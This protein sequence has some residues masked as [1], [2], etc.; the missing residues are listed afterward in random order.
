MYCMVLLTLESDW[1]RGLMNNMS[2]LKLTNKDFEVVG[3]NID[4]SERIVRVSLTYWNDAWRRLK[5]NRLAL[6]GLIVIVAVIV[7]AIVVPF[8]T[9]YPYDKQFYDAISKGPSAEHLFG[10]DDLGRDL[11]SRCWTGART[12]LT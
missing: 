10:T 6:L 5:E 7:L 2:N 12:S 3:K 9:R 4:E 11:F 8:V 1:I